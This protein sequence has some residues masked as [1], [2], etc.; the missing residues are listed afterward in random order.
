VADSETKNEMASQDV[1]D[2]AVTFLE[3]SYEALE[4]AAQDAKERNAILNA[5]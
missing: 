2:A 5:L 3:E 4:A 1:K